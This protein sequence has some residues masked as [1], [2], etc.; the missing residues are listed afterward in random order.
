MPPTD[1]RETPRPPSVFKPLRPASLGWRV[2]LFVAG[3]LLWVAALIAT[4]Y[5]LSEGKAVQ[6]ALVVI[7]ISV[8][9]ATVVLLAMR[10]H[11]LRDEERAK[12]TA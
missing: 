4:A 7:A 11:R 3:P 8:L 6:F 9:L 1:E 5:A 12:E 2:F 10:L